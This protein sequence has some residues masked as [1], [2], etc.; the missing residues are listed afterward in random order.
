VLES[1]L[2]NLCALDR[3]AAARVPAAGRLQSRGRRAASS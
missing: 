1:A 2:G 3:D